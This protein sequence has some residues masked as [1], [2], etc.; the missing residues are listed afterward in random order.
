ML[1]EIGGGRARNEFPY[2]ADQSREL[3][4]ISQTNTCQRH[5]DSMTSRLLLPLLLLSLVSVRCEEEDTQELDLSQMLQMGLS[6]GK[7]YLG[8]DGVD[9]L[10]KGDFSQLLQLGEKFLG[11]G[12]VNDLISAAA[13]EFLDDQ[14]KHKSDSREKMV[15]YVMIQQYSENFVASTHSSYTTYFISYFCLLINDKVTCSSNFL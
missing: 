2:V 13:K 3:T 1:P 5:S 9:R 8:Q 15:R 7:Q 11:E 14:E 12:T 4:E 10:K 6:L